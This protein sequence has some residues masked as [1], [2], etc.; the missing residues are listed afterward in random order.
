MPRRVTAGST[1]LPP[2]F[3]IIPALLLAL[4]LSATA[5][6]LE[7]N[8]IGL[9]VNNLDREVGF[10]SGVLSF[11]KI[12]ETKTST[13]DSDELFGLTDA[14]THSVDLALGSEKITLTEHLS[15]KGRP[16][17]PDSR[18]NDL[19][20]QHIAIVVRDMDAA[21]QALQSHKIKYVS[22]APQTLPAWNKNAGG[23]QAFYFRDPEDHTLELIYFPPGKGDPKWRQAGTNIFLGIDHTAITV[24][25]T[26]K[27]LGFYRDQLGMRVAGESENFGVEQEHLNQVFGARLRITALRAERGPGIELLEYITPPGGRPRP[28]DSAA[29]DLI[30]WRTHLVFTG[31]DR[32]SPPSSIQRVS[33]SGA[34][35][36][37]II[38]DPDGHALQLD[39]PHA[40]HARTE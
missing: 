32:L 4:K 27:S 10:F 35:E 19:W 30:F 3:W 36:S 29:N 37:L 14:Q 21:Y 8:S 7:V 17:P 18:G 34:A 16:I 28:S 6:V 25:D 26:E 22:T 9:T 20:F 11:R 38:R 33:K 1:G 5:E 13:G 31:V 2:R 39:N 12:S 15:R 23:I 24:S 40:V